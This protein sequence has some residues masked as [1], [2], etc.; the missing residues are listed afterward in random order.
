[1]SNLT[2]HVAL[3]TGGGTGI[4]R[5]V[6]LALAKQGAKIVVCGRRRELLA[7]TVAAIKERD[8]HALA[9]Q[10]DVTETETV[11]RVVQ[12]TVD[13]FGT[14]NI[15]INNA[16]IYQTGYIHEHD[17]EAWDQV[18]AINLRGPFLFARTVLPL[19]RAQRQG[20][21]IN[22]SSNSGIDYFPGSGAYGVSKHALNALSEFIQRENQD[23]S[24]RVDTVCPGMV[25]TPMAENRPGLIPEKCLLPEDIA[26][27]V[28][29]LLTCR[30][31]IKIGRP[32]LIEPMESPWE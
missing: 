32:I 25:L 21:I 6:A 8:G 9:M 16:G 13:R 31:N 30:T 20:H 2:D 29:W 26:D 18:M 12:S 14:V 28:L 15:L 1:M 4:G 24:I 17:I 7:E 22:L 27:L 5:A 23:F 11:Q 19:M 3:V 10:A